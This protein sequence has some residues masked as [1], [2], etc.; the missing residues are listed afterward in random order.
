MTSFAFQFDLVL[1]FSSESPHSTTYI[2]YIIPI[3]LQNEKKESD[4]LQLII[5]LIN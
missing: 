1:H 4:D 5:F 3:N 2:M